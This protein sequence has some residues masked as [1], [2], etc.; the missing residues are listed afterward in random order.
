MAMEVASFSKDPSTKV[1]AVIVNEYNRFVSMGY[2]GFPRKMKDD[3][4]LHDRSLKYPRIIHAEINAILFAQ[5]DLEGCTLYTMPFMPCE[6]CAP[7]IIQTGIKRVVS[8]FSNN[9]RWTDSFKV[10]KDMF[11]ETGVELDIITNPP[12]EYFGVTQ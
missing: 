2:N 7:V 8:V 1:G 9:P 10:A 12:A 3:N 11:D 4:R 6:K 5:R